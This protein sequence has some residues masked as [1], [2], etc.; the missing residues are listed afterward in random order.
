[1]YHA[2]K[3]IFFTHSYT[4]NTVSFSRTL[5]TLI[6]SPKPRVSAASPRLHRSSRSITRIYLTCICLSCLR[7]PLML[8]IVSHTRLVCQSCCFLYRVVIQSIVS[9]V[10]KP[11]LDPRRFVVHFHSRFVS[12]T[13][14]GVLQLRRVFEYAE[15]ADMFWDGHKVF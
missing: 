1:M 6:W 12:L 9:P 13:L 11:A 15:H 4:H 7:K 3:V 14:K 10:T 5:Y 2:A 8:P